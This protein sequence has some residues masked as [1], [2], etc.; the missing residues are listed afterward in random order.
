MNHFLF[1]AL[2]RLC[3]PP[4][5]KEFTSE[6]R[7]IFGIFPT[8]ALLLILAGIT[9]AAIILIVETVKRGGAEGENAC[10]KKKRKKE[11]KK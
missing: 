11:K 5:Y 2:L 1:A 9:M 10:R 4:P 3:T 6:D 7:M 8:W